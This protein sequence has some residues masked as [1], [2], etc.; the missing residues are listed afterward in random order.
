MGTI[1]FPFILDYLFFV[2]P[3]RFFKP[4]GISYI[5]DEYWFFVASLFVLTAAVLQF[6]CNEEEA[7]HCDCGYDLS[8]M[9]TKSKHCPECGEG[10]QLEWTA[11]PGELSRKTTKRLYWAI[12]LLCGSFVVFVFG[13]IAKMANGWASA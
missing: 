12:F 11:I 1:A 6:P 4:I 13:L 10:V 2:H 9:N 8:F 3:S 7:W 5:L